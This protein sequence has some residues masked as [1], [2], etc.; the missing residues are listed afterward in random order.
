MNPNMMLYTCPFCDHTEEH[1]SEKLAHQP[2]YYDLEPEYFCPNH[3]DAVKLEESGR[4][5]SGR[6]LN[7]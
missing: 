2:P 7:G 1:Y 5:V 3:S 4:V 6:L